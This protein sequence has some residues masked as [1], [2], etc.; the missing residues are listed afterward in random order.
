MSFDDDYFD[1][2]PKGFEYFMETVAPDR[3]YNM[4]LVDDYREYCR[5]TDDYSF[6]RWWA[7]LDMDE[8]DEWRF[9]EN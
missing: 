3:A 4:V 6:E 5:R 2:A 8:Y 9:F 7:Q 1:E